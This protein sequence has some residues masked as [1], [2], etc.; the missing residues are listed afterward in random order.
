MRKI[1]E[2]F[3]NASR[4]GYTEVVQLLL[5]AGADVRAGNDYA[6]RRASYYGHT[7][8]VQ[9]LLNAGADVHAKD[10][11]TIRYASAYGH[12]EVVQLLLAHYRENNLK[13]PKGL[14]K[15]LTVI[16]N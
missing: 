3:A 10:D 4:N 9:L 14:R 7:E 2:D 15:R 16:A 5:N 6:I 8:V 12:T 13:I 1:D 11:Y